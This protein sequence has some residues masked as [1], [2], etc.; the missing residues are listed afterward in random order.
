MISLALVGG[1]G[2]AFIAKTQRRE[3][4]KKF[5]RISL[6]LRAFASLRLGCGRSPRWE[7]RVIRGSN[8]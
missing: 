7:I 8:S 1:P 3:N 2:V 6:R 5:I 4:T